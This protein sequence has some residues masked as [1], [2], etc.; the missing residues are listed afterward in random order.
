[1]D[2]PDSALVYYLAQQKHSVLRY[3][4]LSSLARGKQIKV[5]GKVMAKDSENDFEEEGKVLFLGK[6]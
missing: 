4:L 5:G 2:T 1:M 3:E 6:L